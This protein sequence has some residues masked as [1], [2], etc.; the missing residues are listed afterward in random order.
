MAASKLTTRQLSVDVAKHSG[1]VPALDI[2]VFG[3]DDD[4][5]RLTRSFGQ[6]LGCV[7]AAH[8]LPVVQIVASIR[9]SVDRRR[10]RA[11]HSAHLR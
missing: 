2:D 7:V 4:H 3:S 8:S 5:G 11:S 1:R 9:L 6:G 10:R